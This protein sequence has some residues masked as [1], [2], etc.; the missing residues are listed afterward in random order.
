MNFFWDKPSLLSTLTGRLQQA[1]LNA[2][3]ALS[4]AFPGFGPSLPFTSSSSIVVLELSVDSCSEGK[5][6]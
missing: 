2:R 5:T 3:G 4:Q 1:L 6:V